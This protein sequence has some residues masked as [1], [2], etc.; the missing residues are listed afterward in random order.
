[1]QRK[2]SALSEATL[3]R[4][5]NAL[6]WDGVFSQAIGVLTGGTLLTG[7]ALE[8]GASPAFIGI[9]VAVPF[10]A[11][12]AHL[13]AIVLVEKL[14]RRRAICL[15]ATSLARLMLLPLLAVPFVSDRSLALGLLLA[16][17][18]VLTPLGAIGGCSWMSWTCDL[19]PH[20]RLGQVFGRRQLRANVSAVAAG[21]LGGAIVSAWATLHPGWR[22]GGYVG[23]FA[24]AIAA[25]LA[26]TWCLTRMPDVPMPAPKPITLPA[27][28]ARPFREAN[29]RRVMIF[30]GSWQFVANLALPFFPVYL[31]QHLHYRISTAIALTIIGQFASVAAVPFWARLSDRWSNKTAILLS[32][33]VF[34]ICLFGWALAVPW[35]PN[36][37]SFPLIVAV[38]LILGAATAGL[39]LACGN[40][41]LKLA[42]KGEATV[43]LGA[44]GVVKSL[45]AGCAPIAG[46]ALVAR[47]ADWG[48]IG[49]A[50]W[51][52]PIWQL[53]FVAA[54]LLGALAL[55]QLVRIEEWGEVPVTV[56]LRSAQR[57]A[58]VSV[59]AAEQDFLPETTNLPAA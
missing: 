54:G 29:F 31:V 30:L 25:A 5:L 1:M 27:L 47:L 49:S 34:L 50:A 13:P 26:S 45:C 10:F 15:A 6:V 51:P 41:A 56:L 42:P 32:A 40:I 8:F 21:L 16:A 55:I 18:A 23:V 46:G 12:F 14:R 2:P 52:M 43:F 28:F 19:V 9:L 38:Q 57:A 33:P 24:V 36:P 44:N 58:S 39:D 48:G 37:I 4:G 59:P 7:C 22:V 35:V 3:E 11:Q 20:H 53:L 17:F